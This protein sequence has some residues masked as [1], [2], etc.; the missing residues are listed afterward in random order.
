MGGSV[1]LIDGHIDDDNKSAELLYLERALALA[2]SEKTIADN[3]VAALELA[4][5]KARSKND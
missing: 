2:R 4:V 3:R 1:S 5:R